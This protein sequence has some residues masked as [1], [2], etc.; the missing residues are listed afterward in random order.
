MHY[1][2]LVLVLSRIRRE[3]EAALVS[4]LLAERRSHDQR[5]MRFSEDRPA[6]NGCPRVLDEVTL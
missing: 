2:G 6:L 5:M 1:F 4:L 3:T